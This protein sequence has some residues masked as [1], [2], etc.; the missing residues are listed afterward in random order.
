M[1][2]SV[3]VDEGASSKDRERLTQLEIE[4]KGLRELLEICSTSKIRIM[5][6]SDSGEDL[7]R[8]ENG[9]SAPN[10]VGHGVSLDGFSSIKMSPA[11]YGKKESE[12]R[13]DETD[14]DDTIMDDNDAE[15]MSS[16]AQGLE[17]EMGDEKQETESDEKSGK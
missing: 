10:G 5:E 15:E 14:D 11:K 1:Q 3:S 2:K 12:A 4:N 16:Q 6:N 17:N 8:E 13:D 7:S 9:E